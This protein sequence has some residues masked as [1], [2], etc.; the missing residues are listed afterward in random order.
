M[1]WMIFDKYSFEKEKCLC[2]AE[3][4]RSHYEQ[5]S[6]PKTAEQKI[7]MEMLEGFRHSVTLKVPANLKPDYRKAVR[8]VHRVYYKGYS[9]ANTRKSSPKPPKL[10]VCVYL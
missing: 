8:G 3:L 6:V 2:E 7:L 9:S 5:L 10:R 1:I 4:F